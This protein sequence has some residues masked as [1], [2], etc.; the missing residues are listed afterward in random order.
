MHMQYKN[1]ITND[2]VS[3]FLIHVQ[4]MSTKG[5]A[6]FIR[7]SQAKIILQIVVHTKKATFLRA[8][9]HQML[10]QGN[11]VHTKQELEPLKAS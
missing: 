10:F 5:N 6:L 4:H 8:L 1:T 9:T 11:Y 2:Q 3:P 7:L